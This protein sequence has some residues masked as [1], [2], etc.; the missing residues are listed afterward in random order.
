M[1]R[2][3]LKYLAPLCDIAGRWEEEVSIADGTSLVDLARQRAAVYGASYRK[4]F[5]DSTGRFA[6]MFTILRNGEPMDEFEASVSDGDRFTFVPP[7]A[8]G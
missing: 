3:T 6:P 1:P 8:G 4:L 2:V 5:F 7:I